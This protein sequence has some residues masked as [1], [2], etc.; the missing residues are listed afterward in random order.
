MNTCHLKLQVIFLLDSH[1]LCSIMP[2]L[3]FSGLCDF[4]NSKST[5]YEG[6]CY[7]NCFMVL[8]ISLS[9]KYSPQYPVLG[10]ALV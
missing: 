9:P 6:L 1:V 7:V 4:Y 5:K 2:D 10:T 8:L 3:N